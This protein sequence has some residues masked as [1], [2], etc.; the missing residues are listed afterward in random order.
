MVCL[1]FFFKNIALQLSLKVKPGLAIF[2]DC[3]IKDFTLL[4]SEYYSATVAWI[5]VENVTHLDWRQMTASYSQP[6][7]SWHTGKLPF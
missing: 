1:Q 6:R 7:H 3:I 2:K 5:T 4:A